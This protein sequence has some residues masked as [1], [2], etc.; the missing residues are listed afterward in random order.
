MI[1]WFLNFWGFKWGF[2]VN[3]KFCDRTTKCKKYNTFYFFMFI[4]FLFGEQKKENEPKER[5]TRNQN[6]L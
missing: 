5:K 4:F 2:M 3:V 6:R 1:Y